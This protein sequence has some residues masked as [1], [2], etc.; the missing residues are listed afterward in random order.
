MNK[1]AAL[2]FVYFSITSVSAQFNDSTFHMVRL[3][4]TGVINRTN[5]ASSYALTNGFRFSTSKK[6]IVFNSSTN[7]LYGR[8]QDRLTNNDFATSLDFNWYHTFEHFYYWGLSNYESSFSLKVNNR[9]QLGL[10]A[11]YN[12]VD[13]KNTLVNISNGILYEYS[14]LKINDSTRNIYSTFRN[15]FRFRFRLAYNDR[16]VFDGVSFIQNSLE[17]KY[18]YILN[19]TTNLS[20]KLVKWMS[21]TSSL[22]YNRLNRTNRENLLLTFGITAEK[23]F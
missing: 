22:T 12:I 15:S 23:Y 10:G 9:S 16:I 8:Q 11:A 19:S 6:S 1:L 18:D 13:K 3:A 17:Y 4:S 20:F 2:V 14:D 21:L 5:D 7:W